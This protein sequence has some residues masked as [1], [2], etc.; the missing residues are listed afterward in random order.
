VCD[1]CVSGANRNSTPTCTCLSHFYEDSNL[2]CIECDNNCKECI[3]SS[4]N[5]TECHGNNRKIE[6]PAC[7]C[8]KGYYDDG[9]NADCVQCPTGC[10][11][12]SNANTCTECEHGYYLDGNDCT[13]CPNKF[14][15]CS[16]STTG[17][18]C[19][20]GTGR[21]GVTPDCGC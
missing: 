18:E 6:F 5:C 15:K 12:C 20:S 2:D 19:A 8:E 1:S 13:I 16:D 11:E 4:D 17:I 14:T 9:T 7:L 3:N 21:T 10:S